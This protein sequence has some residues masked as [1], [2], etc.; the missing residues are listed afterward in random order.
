MK[1]YWVLAIACAV[2]CSFPSS[3]PAE[4]GI[5]VDED[6]DL[7][8][9]LRRANRLMRYGG[10]S[11][12][13]KH[14]QVLLEHEPLSYVGVHFIMGQLHEWKGEPREAGILYQSYL[15]LG[16]DKDALDQARAGLRRVRNREWSQLSVNVG[17]DTP[18]VVKLNGYIVAKDDHLEGLWLPRGT[19]TVAVELEDHHEEVF[20]A[21]MTGEPLSLAAAPKKKTFFGGLLVQ[22]RF[23]DR[24]VDGATVVVRQEKF[25]GE[26]PLEQE[27]RVSTPMSEPLPLPTGVYFIEVTDDDHQRW[28]RRL[29]VSRHE[30]VVVDARL[31]PALP[32]EIRPDPR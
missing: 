20:E 22:A 13:M 15:A 3:T 5:V 25:D 32:K 26:T 27:I 6:V 21:K 7:D 4:T 19:Y 12:A 28:V 14:Y 30:E 16:Q 1:R 17:S 8:Y 9:H 29:Y 18:G 24:P 10:M 11:R 23:R 31:T 2:L